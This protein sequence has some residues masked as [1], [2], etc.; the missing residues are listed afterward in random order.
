MDHLTHH[1][2]TR[3]PVLMIAEFIENPD[4]LQKRVGSGLSDALVI[5]GKQLYQLQGTLLD[6]WEEVI[7][8][9]RKDSA[10]CVS[11]DLLLNGDG[12]VDVE[13]LIEIDIFDLQGR[14]TV[15]ICIINDS[16]GI[17]RRR[18]GGKSGHCIG[19]R[20]W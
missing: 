12:A 1:L 20:D 13:H 3:M 15:D 6:I 16:D 2:G 14:I 10:N 19:V 8:S 4:N 18:A 17:G 7:A 5:M 11:S 9:C